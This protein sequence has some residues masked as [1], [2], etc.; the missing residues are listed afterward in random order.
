VGVVGFSSPALSDL[1]AIHRAVQASPLFAAVELDHEAYRVP[2]EFAAP[3]ALGDGARPEVIDLGALTTV[4]RELRQAGRR[5]TTQPSLPPPFGP[6]PLPA[7]A[8]ETP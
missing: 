7:Q 2:F 8:P 5:F 4:T 3:I 6:G 1:I